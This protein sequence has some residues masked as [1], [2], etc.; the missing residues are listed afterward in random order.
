MRGCAGEDGGAAAAAILSA[1]GDP[2]PP[3]KGRQG[4]QLWNSQGLGAGA[5]TPAWQ[6]CHL[7]INAR[8]L[9]MSLVC[10]SVWAVSVP[11]SSK[12]LSQDYSAPTFCC[13]LCG[14]FQCPSGA[15]HA[16]QEVCSLKQ[17]CQAATVS[18][19]A[20]QLLSRGAA[21]GL[22]MRAHGQ[23]VP[24]MWLWKRG[25]VTQMIACEICKCVAGEDGCTEGGDWESDAA[26]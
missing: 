1:G 25:G 20:A 26:G 7:A 6:T 14:P 16:V 8:S 21:V 17:Q 4:S 13:N 22:C 15:H 9:L 19:R 18:S 3:R 24:Q 2:G 11:Q 5:P 23:S 12:S 10:N